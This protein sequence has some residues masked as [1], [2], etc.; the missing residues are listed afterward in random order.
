MKWR[1]A[2]YDIQSETDIGRYHILG[3]LG[4]GGMAVTYKAY[5]TNVG[6]NPNLDFLVY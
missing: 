6:N 4:E 2:I 1:I 3:Q 5:D